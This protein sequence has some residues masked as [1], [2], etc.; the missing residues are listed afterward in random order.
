MRTRSTG[1]HR[2]HFGSWEEMSNWS[3][4]VWNSAAGDRGKKTHNKHCSFQENWPMIHHR[5]PSQAW[6]G[7][8]LSHFDLAKRYRNWWDSVAFNVQ[9]TQGVL[10]NRS[11]I[12]AWLNPDESERLWLWV[13]ESAGK[14]AGMLRRKSNCSHLFSTL[15]Q[16]YKAETQCWRWWLSENS[17]TEN[18]QNLS[19]SFPFW[20]FPVR[21]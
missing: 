13:G 10:Y 16:D 21:Y 14:L 1:N 6:I 18:S 7:Q 17:Q 20:K 19:L 12:T 11:A 8:N 3:T 2:K 4:K 15:S 5:R 9:G